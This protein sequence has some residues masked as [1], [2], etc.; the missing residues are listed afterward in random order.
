MKEYK[1][2]NQKKDKQELFQ[3]A[4]QFVYE[5][6]HIQKGIGTLGEKTVH[7]AVKQFF[8]SRKE[9]QEQPAYGFVADIKNKDGIIEI[10]TRNFQALRKKLKVFLEHEKVTIVYPIPHK[11]WLYWIDEETGEV[12]KKRKSPKEGNVYNAFFELYKIKEYLKHPNL[13]ICLLFLDI[14][15]YRLLNGWSKDKKKGSTRYDRIPIEWI[16]EIWIKEEKEYEKLLPKEGLMEEFTVKDFIKT[17]GL[18][19][20]CGALGIQILK[21]TD[22][23]KQVGKQGR[24][25]LYTKN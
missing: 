11:K 21:A 3:K 2:I 14:E 4:C 9:Y 22:Q 8:E 12:T 20:R 13:S 6:Q 5:K 16:E 23:I 19:S 1:E 24:A 25:Y 18:S 15:E 17:T 7:A 10:Q